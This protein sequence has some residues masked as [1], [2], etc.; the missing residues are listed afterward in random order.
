[1]IYV[2]KCIY[3]RILYIQCE[4]L[5]GDGRLLRHRRGALAPTGPLE[6][7]DLRPSLKTG[8]IRNLEWKNSVDFN[9]L[10][11]VDPKKTEKTGDWLVFI[12][13]MWLYCLKKKILMKRKLKPKPLPRAPDIF[14]DLLA[15]S[16][17]QD[18]W[19]TK[20]TKKTTLLSVESWLFNR[21]PDN[22]YNGLL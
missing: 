6:F 8:E 14:K 3:A 9:I 19:A 7:H 10:E 2:Y 21:D 18:R 22:I 12:E 11:K 5:C 20:K 4:L 15:W 1:M 17:N 16:S 13:G